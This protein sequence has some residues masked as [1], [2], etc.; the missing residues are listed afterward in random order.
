MR[1][2]RRRNS[3]PGSTLGEYAMSLSTRDMARLGLLM[4]DE[5]RWQGKQVTPSA[6]VSFLTSLVTPRSDT[7]PESFPDDG[8]HERWG[9]GYLWWVWN[10]RPGPGPVYTG[11]Y[12]GTYSA[13][14]TGE[15]TSLLPRRTT[16]L[17]FT[18]LIATATLLPRSSPPAIW[19]CCLC[20]SMHTAARCVRLLRNGTRGDLISPHKRCCGK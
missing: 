18:S 11:A 13:M 20:W 2:S 7:H 12:D 17:S 15:I 1:I 19:R 6:W 16:W 5:G 8:I 14:G 4:L 10:E 3:C 9:Y